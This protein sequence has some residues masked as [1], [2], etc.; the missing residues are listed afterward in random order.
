MWLWLVAKCPFATRRN[1]LGLL[2][3]SFTMLIIAHHTPACLRPQAVALGPGF[4]RGGAFSLC[5]AHVRYRINLFY[6]EKTRVTR[7]KIA[8]ISMP[9]FAILTKMPRDPLKLSRRGAFRVFFG[10]SFALVYNSTLLL[11]LWAL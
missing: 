8:K 5:G 4:G 7:T 3:G 2:V 10:A 1:S 9:S 6:M 11:A